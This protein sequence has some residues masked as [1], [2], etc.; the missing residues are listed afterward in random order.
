MLGKH[1]E[2]GPGI[3]VV[4]AVR[5]GLISLSRL[6]LLVPKVSDFS[7]ILFSIFRSVLIISA[8]V[9]CAWVLATPS[10]P[11]LVLF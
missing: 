9:K 3:I 1:V 5:S 8:K 6:K 2:A 7:A 11:A 10:L 4:L